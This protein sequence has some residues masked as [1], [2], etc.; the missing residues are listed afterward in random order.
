MPVKA[1][2]LFWLALFWFLDFRWNQLWLLVPQ[3]GEHLSVQI[4]W[5]LSFFVSSLHPIFTGLCAGFSIEIVNFQ[6]LLNV[7]HFFN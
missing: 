3:K 2:P 5:S 6:D 4:F 7:T 1:R